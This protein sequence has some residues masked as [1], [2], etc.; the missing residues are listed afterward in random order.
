VESHGN[1][2]LSLSR[3]PPVEIILRG[4]IERHLNL[5]VTQNSLNDLGFVAIPPGHG[6][7]SRKES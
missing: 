1:E 3:N 5:V 2:K 7:E 4:Q 6:G